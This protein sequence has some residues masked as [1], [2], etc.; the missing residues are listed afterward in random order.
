MAL[1]TGREGR[2]RSQFPEGGHRASPGIPCPAAPTLSRGWQQASP[3]CPAC[4]PP[5]PEAQGQVQRGF[6]GTC[7]GGV[8][9]VSVGSGAKGG[10]VQSLS[11]LE[12]NPTCI[13]P[14]KYSDVPNTSS[15]GWM[16]PFYLVYMWCLQLLPEEQ[17]MR[18]GERSGAALLPPSVKL[19][20]G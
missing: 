14:E 20:H 3:K 19:I 12:A 9:A 16:F 8:A 4:L 2:G 7:G 10:T 13:S 17:R 5:L 11:A 6:G 18:E 15:K 1:E